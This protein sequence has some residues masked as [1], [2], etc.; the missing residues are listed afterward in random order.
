MMFK[1]TYVD[2]FQQSIFQKRKKQ[3]ILV[4]QR[5]KSNLFFV[6]L[7]FLIPII[8]NLSAVI[9]YFDFAFVLLKKIVF[10]SYK[11]EGQTLEVM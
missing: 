10:C 7:V 9:L 4:L 11:S 1:C 8:F 2:E 3:S 6:G 5:K